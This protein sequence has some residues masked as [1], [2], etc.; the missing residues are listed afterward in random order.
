MANYQVDIEVALRGARELN[1]LKTS[2][3]SVNKEV[4]RLNAATI[5]AGRALK[6]TFSAKDIGNVNN[7]SKAVAKAE[8]ALRNAAFGTQAEERAVKALVTAQKEFNEQLARQN[9]LL[10]EEERLQGVNQPVPKAPKTPKARKAGLQTFGISGIDFM[11]IGGGAN[12]PGSPLAKQAKSRARF[13]S[14]VSAGAFPLLF[15]GGPGMALGGALGGAI[16][17]STFGP[18]SIALQVL[19]GVFDQLAAQAAS[20]GAALNP[21]TAD[22]DAIVESL[23]MVG[24]PAQDAIQSLEELAGEQ[25]ALEEATRQL[26]LV[27]GDE[28]VEALAAFGDAST[29]FSNALT[30]VTTQILAQIARLTGPIVKEIATSM[31]IGAL[32]SAAQASKDPRQ[33]A[34]QE[35]LAAQP[36]QAGAKGMP[37]GAG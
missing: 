15:G 30:Q 34:L 22:I 20:L 4:G 12:I 17:G 28:G 26:S 6:G 23:G 2:L 14:A 29:R 3:K 32:L 9:K 18:A 19:G 1:V 25:V 5:K 7:Y 33:I 24:S 13:G 36:V 31:E 27:V 37:S 11:P 8:R 10:K 21:A 16:S 35:K